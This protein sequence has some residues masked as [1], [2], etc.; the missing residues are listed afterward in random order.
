MRFSVVITSHAGEALEFDCAHES[1]LA[2]T[3]KATA[4]AIT[5]HGWATA[6]LMIRKAARLKAE[7]E[8]HK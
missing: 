4:D 3:L 8:S 2:W 5:K 6:R 7:A 1:D